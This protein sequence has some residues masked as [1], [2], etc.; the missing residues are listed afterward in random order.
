MNALEALNTPIKPS[1]RMRASKMVNKAVSWA[2]ASTG[3]GVAA[4]IGSTLVSGPLAMV[5]VGVS[6]GLL[7]FTGVTKKVAPRKVWSLLGVFWL[8]VLAQSWMASSAGLIL[9]ALALIAGIAATRKQGAKFS[10]ILWAYPALIAAG[11][12]F[13][14]NSLTTPFGSSWTWLGGIFGPL[15]LAQLLLVPDADK[16]AVKAEKAQ[17]KLIAK[18]E[19]ELA[20]AAAKRSFKL[21][22]KKVSK[23]KTEKVSQ[24]ADIVTE[25]DT[26]EPKIL[27]PGKSYATVDLDKMQKE[28]E[29]LLAKFDPQHK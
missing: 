17:D 16:E 5:A 24:S 4:W 2:L 20:K 25:E 1:R 3:V 22:K 12:Y 6:L 15:L 10:L 26:D 27:A 11:L 28:R 21:F 9:G 14:G 7:V 8:V 23:P 13:T 29:L 18:A 19:K